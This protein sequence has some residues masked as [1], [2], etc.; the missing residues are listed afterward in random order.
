MLNISHIHTNTF[1]SLFLLALKVSL[2]IVCSFCVQVG[3]FEPEGFC[4]TVNTASAF[5]GPFS[6]SMLNAKSAKNA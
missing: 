4:L 2:R 3:F 6:F 1:R 5:Y